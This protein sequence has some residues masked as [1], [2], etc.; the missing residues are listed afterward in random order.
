M[1][2]AQAKESTEEIPWQRSKLMVIGAAR[3][4]K[5]STVRSLLNEPFSPNMDST[6]GI[7][8]KEIKTM[9]KEGWQETDRGE[10]ASSIIYRKAF[11]NLGILKTSAKRPG[12]W[13]PRKLKHA[14]KPVSFKSFGAMVK[15]K[16]GELRAEIQN[17]NEVTVDDHFQI[18]E[19]EFVLRQFPESLEADHKTGQPNE[20]DRIFQAGV[21]SNSIRM[22]IWDFG[23]QT[24]FYT[25]HHLFLT[26]YGIYLLVF[27]IRKMMDQVN[28]TLEFM[29][30][31]INSVSLHAPDAKMVVVGTFFL[32]IAKHVKSMDGMYSAFHPLN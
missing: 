7:D 20:S 32:S 10:F 6:V 27:D 9:E 19:N 23:G 8:L 13:R 31:W 15:R 24:V 29:R 26:R 22:S 30:F 12:F 25:L 11:Q 2:V 28:E 14:L 17:Q 4:G 16:L 18:L 1:A 5:T 21:E 3:V